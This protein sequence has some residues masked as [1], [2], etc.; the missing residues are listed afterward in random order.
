MFRLFAIQAFLRLSC[1]FHGSSDGSSDGNSIGS[2]DGNSI[3]GGTGAGTGGGAGSNT[4]GG[5]GNLNHT[6][7]TDYQLIS[8][9]QQT[10][11]RSEED[12]IRSVDMLMSNMTASSALN[13]LL[14]NSLA[15]PELISL[16]EQAL[17]L[18]GD[19]GRGNGNLRKRGSGN[20]FKIHLDSDKGPAVDKAVKMLN[21]MIME[22]M[23]AYDLE[24]A[25]CTNY[26]TEQCGLMEG[27]RGEIAAANYKAAHSRELILAAQT[28]VSI[29]QVALPKLTTELEAHEKKCKESIKDLEGKLEIVQAD[30]A[31]MTMI[32]EMTDC[33]KTLLQ[34]ESLGL[35]RC[36]DTCKREFVTFTNSSLRKE[37]A[38]LQSPL[39]QR[40]IKDSFA[41]LLFGG[42]VEQPTIELVQG[43]MQVIQPKGKKSKASKN[44][45]EG[46]R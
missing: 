28:Q 40:L 12:H 15:T 25:K 43:E 5:A 27:C 26:Y 2:S 17:G 16:A 24:V 10:F 6:V 33:E 32:L 29:S 42:S 36:E 9:M 45:C 39:S 23:E 41:D 4:G 38:A 20:G 22:S 34:A 18:A 1:G 8:S 30:I 35:L 46:E 31:I 21:E 11:E 14:N 7:L 13:V 3:G 44:D 19:A 37:V